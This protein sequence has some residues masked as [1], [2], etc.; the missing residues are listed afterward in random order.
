MFNAPAFREFVKNRLIGGK[1]QIKFAEE[2]NI[3]PQYLSRMLRVDNPPR[4]SKTTLKKLAGDSE[5]EYNKLLD[6]CGYNDTASRIILETKED[7]IRSR[8]DELIAGLREMTH[9]VHVY[10]NLNA[11][12]EDYSLMFDSKNVTFKFAG[13]RQEYDEGDHYC[14]EYVLPVSALYRFGTYE[15]RI[16]FALFFSETKG[17]KTVVLDMALDGETLVRLGFPFPENTKEDLKK[18]P[19]I[20]TL[21]MDYAAEER[22][23]EAIFGNN[24]NEEV[25]V[26]RIGFGISFRDS[27]LKNSVI[28]DFLEKH[29]SAAVIPE[30]NMILSGEPASK[31]LKGY[32]TNADAGEG[33]GCLVAQ[34]IREETGIDFSYYQDVTGDENA[35]S[36]IMVER[37]ACGNYDAEELKQVSMELAKDLGLVEYGEC[38][39]YI[40]DYINGNQRFRLKEEEK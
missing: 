5:T 24:R 12:L 19:Y 27:M 22:L 7:M 14:A 39:V 25:T 17:G 3:S 23:L 31:V 34:V 1:T 37:E 40:H 21:R 18:K 13:S 33:A 9:G 20:S 15:C 2:R 30:A 32:E 11:F 16:L 35:R 29:S 10:E 38:L 36:T 28:R 8:V 4:P 26:S 6:L